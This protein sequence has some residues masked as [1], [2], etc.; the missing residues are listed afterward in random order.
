VSRIESNT[1][2]LQRQKTRI[3]RLVEEVVDDVQFRLPRD[4]NIR[5]VV[6]STLPP[7][8]EELEVDRTRIM[9]VL[10]NMLD[11]AVNSTDAAGEIRVVLEDDRESSKGY[12]RVS[13]IDHGR[14]IDPS[15]MPKL[16]GKFISNSHKGGGT[17][18]GLYLSKAI[19]EAHGGTMRGENNASGRGATFSF[20]LPTAAAGTS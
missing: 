10:A 16:F 4:L 15:I 13:V 9:Q 5:I 11:N 17:G 2:K 14:G 3:K 12:I 20:T 18:L 19:V 1:L 7:E 8:R 6:E